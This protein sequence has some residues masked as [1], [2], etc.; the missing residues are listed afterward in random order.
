MGGGIRSAVTLAVAVLVTGCTTVVGGT[1]RPASG[2][3]PEPVTGAAVRQALLDD[4]TLAKLL[5]QNFRSD[6]HLPPRFGGLDALPDGWPSARPSYCVGT[7][8][9]A[10]KTV[11]RSDSVQEVAQEFWGGAKSARSEVTGVSEGVIALPTAADA[12]VAFE[13]FAAQWNRC[14]GITVTR[15]ADEATGATA[16]TAEIGDVQ[17]GDSVITATVRTTLG[18][19]AMSVTRA[20]GVRVNCLIDVDVFTIG[21][22][23]DASGNNGATAVARAM[24]DKVSALAP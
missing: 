8:V 19:V 21:H 10:Q 6:P 5:D 18:A 7:V 13:K 11:Y 2:L 12:Q 22:G 15:S 20:L 23:A 24:M 17:T 16:A 4:V 1:V 3:I 9:G 14:E